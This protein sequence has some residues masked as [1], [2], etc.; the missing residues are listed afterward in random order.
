MKKQLLEGRLGQS[1]EKIIFA[2][3]YTTCSKPRLI[4]LN[5][6]RNPFKSERPM[7]AFWQAYREHFAQTCHR[8][9]PIAELRFVV[10]DTE[11]TGLEPG[12]SRLLSIGAV[13]V[14]HWQ[15]DLADRLECYLLADGAGEGAAAVPVHGILPNERQGNLSEAAALEDFLAFCRDGV[16]VGHHLGFDVAM[17]NHALKRL[18][19]G[20][21]L[22][23]QLDTLELARRVA[24]GELIYRPGAFSLDGLCQ[25]YHIPMS[26]RHTAAGDAYLTAILLM[27]L[28]ARL[29]KRGVNTLGQ[30]LR[31]RNALW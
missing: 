16:L 12:R 26:D 30:L 6:L 20:K 23:R 19:G 11:T 31:G 29:E 21:L 25:Q 1:A 2:K 24:G 3:E 14:Q 17:I 27:K 28:L 13:A 5:W 7:P 9:T 4:M 22:N 18:G 8:H 15:V 10:F